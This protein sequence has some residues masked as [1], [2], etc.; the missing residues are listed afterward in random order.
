MCE[1]VTKENAMQEKIKKMGLFATPESQ[2]ALLYYIEQF[3]G[4]ERVIAMTIMGMTW[5]FMAHTINEGFAEN[6]ES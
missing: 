2:E 1:P 5:N 6:A 4:N 3:N